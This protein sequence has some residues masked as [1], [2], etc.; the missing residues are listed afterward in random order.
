MQYIYIY[1]H[2]YIYRNLTHKSN[3]YPLTLFAGYDVLP[4]FLPG[5]EHQTKS[6][7]EMWLGKVR[8]IH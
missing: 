4:R 6:E 5:R 1:I 2:T 8:E 7:F 3:W